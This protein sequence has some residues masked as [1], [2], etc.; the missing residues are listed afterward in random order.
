MS[1]IHVKAV[2]RAVSE[3]AYG[4]QI[5][6]PVIDS[7]VRDAF[8]ALYESTEMAA[9][10]LNAINEISGQSEYA[11]P[12]LAQESD[13]RICRL[14]ELYRAS[15]DSTGAETSRI[16][17][18]PSLYRLAL[19]TDKTASIASVSEVLVLRAKSSRTY[20]NGL[21]PVAVVAFGID[22]YIPSMH[23]TDS[24]MAVCAKVIQILASNTGKPWTDARKAT[25]SGETYENA[26]SRI[27]YKVMRGNTGVGLRMN[28]TSQFVI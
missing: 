1:E 12:A 11:L 18:H 24:E 23:L 4:G 17:I 28:C 16:L 7:A 26:I 21:I 10:E 22:N 19:K 20:A 14:S 6:I 3:L 5:S 25:A 9:I 27:K 2:R 8:F 15:Y 13:S